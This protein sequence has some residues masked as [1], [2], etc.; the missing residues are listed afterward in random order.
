[1]QYT[2]IISS[3]IRAKREREGFSLNE[4]CFKNGI[5]PATLSRYE[6]NKRKISLENLVKISKGFNKIPSEFL[7]EFESSNPSSVVL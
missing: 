1:M 2:K 4:F 3:Y 7:A 5:E 6:N